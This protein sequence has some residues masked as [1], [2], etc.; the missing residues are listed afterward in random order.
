MDGNMTSG[1]YRFKVEVS[2][3]EGDLARGFRE[4]LLDEA[5]DLRLT[6]TG[7]LP[8]LGGAPIASW[9]LARLA[10]SAWLPASRFWL[11]LPLL[12]LALAFH[13]SANCREKEYQGLNSWPDVGA[14]TLPSRPLP[15]N[16]VPQLVRPSRRATGTPA[17]GRGSR[18]RTRP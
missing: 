18:R 8:D 15:R 6:G 7:K 3:W 11:P 13:V 12:L 17:G 1:R 5:F 4:E 14:S 16:R 10:P 9:L 2:D